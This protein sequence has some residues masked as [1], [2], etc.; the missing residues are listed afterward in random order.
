[1]GPVDPLL[2]TL[3]GHNLLTC[4]QLRDLD[5]IAQE[6]AA[7]E[8]LL[9][10][11]EQREWLTAYQADH[12]RRGRGERLVVGPYVLLE[13]LGG[14]G[15]GQVFRARHR[16]LER[17]AA[18]KRIHPDHQPNPR[19]AERFLR[20][21]RAG[22]AL[23]HPNIVTVYDFYQDGDE[24]YLSMEFIPGTDLDCH[25]ERHGPLPVVPACD[26]IRQACLG[27]QHAHGRGVVHRDI[28]PRNLIV[29]PDNQVKIIDFGLA[30]RDSDSTITSPGMG[31]GTPDYISP[32]QAVHP[33]EVDG[34]T[35]IY[36]LGCTLYHLLAGHA[37]FAL[38]PFG[39]R[40]AAHRDAPAPHH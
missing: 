38:V 7:V 16:L 21:V 35:D 10:E 37:P 13:P 6:C 31:M 11:L 4:G 2:E 3:R 8:E 17:V 33:H 9:Q 25:V 5:G 39:E 18:L 15:M 27:L 1:M 29:S 22:A 36:S 34:R 23:A 24:F 26:Y 30:R 14:G 28:K 32:E 19:M 12:L 40:V 20:E